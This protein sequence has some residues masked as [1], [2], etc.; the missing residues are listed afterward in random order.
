MHRMMKADQLKACTYCIHKK[1][2]SDQVVGFYSEGEHEW[3]GQEGQLVYENEKE[4]QGPADLFGRQNLNPEGEHGERRQ[5][6]KTCNC[7]IVF[8]NGIDLT[9]GELVSEFGKLEAML[10]QTYNHIFNVRNNQ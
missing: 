7:L 9:L 8:W 6:K 5:S 1:Q 4:N 10:L 3:E 2:T